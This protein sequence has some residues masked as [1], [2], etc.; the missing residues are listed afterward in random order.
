MSFRVPAK[1]DPAQ[2]LFV[3]KNAFY[4][5]YSGNKKDY[6]PVYNH[7][8]QRSNLENQNYSPLNVL[9]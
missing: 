4:W 1:G 7:K 8:R 5:I 6:R 2:G 9:I 3:L